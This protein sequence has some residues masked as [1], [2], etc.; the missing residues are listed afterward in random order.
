MKRVATVAV[1]LFTVLGVIGF[2]H[3]DPVDLWDN[4]EQ[5]RAVQKEQKE[6]EFK[7][8]WAELNDNERAVLTKKV[9]TQRLLEL[10]E[11]FNGKVP[12][13]AHD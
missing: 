4:V 10:I 2:A 12:E 9:R 5:I 1:A 3:Y 8:L 13:V 6:Q 11:D 7:Q